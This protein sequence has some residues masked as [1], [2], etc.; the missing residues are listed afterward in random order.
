MYS[1]FCLSVCSSSFLGSVR[2]KVQGCHCITVASIKQL[3]YFCHI[4][5]NTL[6]EHLSI[7]CLRYNLET[8][9]KMCG[10]LLAKLFDMNPWPA[11]HTR[12]CPGAFSRHYC[13]QTFS[14]V[15][16]IPHHDHLLDTL[17]CCCSS[18]AAR[19]SPI[20]TTVVALTQATTFF[21]FV[22]ITL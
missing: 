16:N 8:H 11:M 7:S 10:H 13:C 9:F 20:T 17:Y 22:N 1:A 2:T 19:N 6:I 15:S 12:C 18:V 14:G 4:M 5:G 21:S 3:P